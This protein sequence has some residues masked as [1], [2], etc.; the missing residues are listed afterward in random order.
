MN[1]IIATDSYKA[2]HWL[3]YPPNTTG[4][5][6][7]IE[8]RAKDKFTVFFGLQAVIEKYL[9]KPITPVDVIGAN[10]FFEKHG[11]PFNVKGWM[12]VV[13]KHGGYIPVRIRAVPEGTIVP[14]GNVLV[15]VESTDPELFWIASYIETLLLR[16]WYPT[17]VAT[18]SYQAKEVIRNALLR[19]ADDL[20]GLPFKLHDFGARGVSSSESAQLGGMSHLVNFMGSDTVEGILAAMM[21]YGNKNN[22]DPFSDMPAF[23][24]PASEHSTITAWGRDNEVEAYR[25]MLKQ[26]GGQGKI[27]AVV[28]DSYDI[29]HACEKLWGEELRQEVIDSGA[30]VVIRPDSGEPREVVVKVAKILD[31]KFGSTVNKRGYKVL[32][33]VRIIQGDGLD[34]E[35]SIQVILDDLI[36]AG[37]SADNIAFGM[38][39]GLLQKLNRDTF[40]FAMKCSAVQVDGEWRDVFKEPITSSG[41]SSKKG[42]L[43]LVREGK[44]F[45]T[46]REE[47]VVLKRDM[48]KE[49]WSDFDKCD[50]LQTVYD[51]GNIVN[52]TTLNEVRQRTGS[53]VW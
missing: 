14:T 45:T 32:N 50:G 26:Y 22:D 39:G 42:R 18:R 31:D 5:F 37:F 51:D 10:S 9:T 34:D 49:G 52:R 11:V 36:A 17:T 8:A 35:Q 19:T 28:S 38:G 25:N 41:K 24:I 16:V 13:E 2:S 15:T 21:Y 23:S 12:R 3:Q 29:Y 44:K 53:W 48:P 47:D 40:Q 27:L 4:M 43:A 46:C 20:S 33:N 7:Y 6:S 30:T 1:P